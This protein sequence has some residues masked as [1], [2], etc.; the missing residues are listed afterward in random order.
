[1]NDLTERIM[2]AYQF[3]A[4]SRGDV[5]SLAD[6]RLHLATVEAHLLNPHLRDLNGQLVQWW[7]LDGAAED[8]GVLTLLEPPGDAPWRE[9]DDGVEIEGVIYTH[10]SVQLRS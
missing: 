9:L 4:P 1:M 5:I 3:I 2:A 7:I 8:R 6:L 10:M